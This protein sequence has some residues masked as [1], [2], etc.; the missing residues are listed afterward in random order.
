MLYNC[1]FWLTEGRPPC[2]VI[3]V[4]SPTPHSPVVLLP[5]H[6]VILGTMLLLASLANGIHMSTL[7]NEIQMHIT[8]ERCI[9][10]NEG[11]T[12]WMSSRKKKWMSHWLL[13][14]EIQEKTRTVLSTRTCAHSVM[15][16]TFQILVGYGQVKGKSQTFF[17]WVSWDVRHKS[18]HNVDTPFKYSWPNRLG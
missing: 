6:R 3:I 12:V 4:Q 8:L 13:P 1:Y 11:T 9:W 10:R 7:V 17:P 18:I 2:H 14:H 5:S 16:Q 15:W